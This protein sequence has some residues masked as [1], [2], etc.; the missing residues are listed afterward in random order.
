MVPTLIASLFDLVTILSTTPVA[1]DTVRSR[2]PMVGSE[3]RTGSSMECVGSHAEALQEWQSRQNKAEAPAT[4]RAACCPRV[5]SAPI[6]LGKQ[7]PVSSQR[8]TLDVCSVL[9]S[10]RSSWPSVVER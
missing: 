7:A 6:S 1:V 10:W 2:L 3:W 4:P 8:R 5:T 9:Q